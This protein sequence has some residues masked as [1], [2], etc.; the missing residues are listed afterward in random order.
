M[1][2]APLPAIRSLPS[3]LLG[4]AAARGRA[5]VAE[6][7]AGQDMRMWHH[8]VLSAVR[9]LAPVAQADL[10]RA[11]ALDPKDLVGILNDLQAAGLTV[12]EPDPRDRRKNAVSL[13]ARGARLLK[14]CETAARAANDELLAPLSAAEREQFTGM[15]R[16]ISG[17]GD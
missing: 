17:T 11:V 13:T 6:A 16:R 15:L 12:R 2:E 4:R 7:L 3:W 10:G 1:S 5:L 8:V 14:R 9:D